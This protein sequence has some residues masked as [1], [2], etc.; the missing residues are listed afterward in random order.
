MERGDRAA[1]GR[2]GGSCFVDSDGHHQR[3]GCGGAGLFGGSVGRD[4]ARGARGAGSI[5][6]FGRDRIG[7]GSHREGGGCRSRRRCERSGAR[8]GAVAAEGDCGARSGRGAQ[9]CRRRDAGDGCGSRS[10]GGAEQVGGRRAGVHERGR[11][12]MGPARVP[13]V[14]EAER[15]RGGRTGRGADDRVAGAREGPAVCEGGCARSA[16]AGAGEVQRNRRAAQ[17]GRPAA[18]GHGQGRARIDDAARRVRCQVRGGFGGCAN[19]R[20]DGVEQPEPGERRGALGKAGAECR[21]A[22]A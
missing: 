7:V 8:S 19:A 15:N 16:R 6:D 5:G 22:R 18:F 11:R 9:I 3:K 17:I 1:A 21:C 2:G 12:W 20:G 4:R 13:G 10:P 14:G